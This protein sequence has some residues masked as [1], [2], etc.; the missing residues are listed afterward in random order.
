M[1]CVEKRCW[2]LVE[3]FSDHPCRLNGCL[4]V[5]HGRALLFLMLVLLQF[6]TNPLCQIKPERG[7]QTLKLVSVLA[8]SNLK[9]TNSSKNI[10]SVT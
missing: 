1:T 10:E 2:E 7:Y 4:L 5:E 9:S 3:P 8:L 6:Q